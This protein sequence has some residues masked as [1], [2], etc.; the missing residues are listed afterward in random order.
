MKYELQIFEKG[1]G[2]GRPRFTKYGGTYTPDRTRIYE[3]M[4]SLKFK[5]KYKIQPSEKPIKATLVLDLNLSK[6]QVKRKEKN[7]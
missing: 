1:I 7:Y 4:I 5:E 3:T 2:K 6:V